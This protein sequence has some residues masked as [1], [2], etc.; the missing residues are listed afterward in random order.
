MRGRGV[1][2]EAAGAALTALYRAIRVSSTAAVT[3][4]TQNSS[5]LSR[6]RACIA[7]AAHRLASGFGVAA[8]RARFAFVL[9]LVAGELADLTLLALKSTLLVGVSTLFAHYAFRGA[10]AGDLF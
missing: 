5:L 4:C 10:D 9:A 8:A 7:Q 3:R 2:L 1:G 6:K